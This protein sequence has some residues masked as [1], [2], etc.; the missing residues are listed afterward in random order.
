M[1]G[2][3]PY[4]KITNCDRHFTIMGLTVILKGKDRDVFVE[5][6]IDLS[7]NPV[8]EISDDDF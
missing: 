7:V 2:T 3:V 1:R 8:G 5:S 6:G 4:R